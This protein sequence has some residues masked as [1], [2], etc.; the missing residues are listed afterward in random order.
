MSAPNIAALRTAV[1]LFSQRSNNFVSSFSALVPTRSLFPKAKLS[2]L[3]NVDAA[4]EQ[5]RSKPATKII[6]NYVCGLTQTVI[7]DTISSGI[8]CNP[9]KYLMRRAR[10]PGS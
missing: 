5:K 4:C 6:S 2:S 3:S 8:D 7:L 10:G 1:V 9:P